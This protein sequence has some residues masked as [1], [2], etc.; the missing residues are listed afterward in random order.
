M[1]KGHQI[2]FLYKASLKYFFSFFE[3]VRSLQFRD[4]IQ[5]QQ[6]VVVPF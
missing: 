5:R 4:A 6:L 1:V 3:K 2:T